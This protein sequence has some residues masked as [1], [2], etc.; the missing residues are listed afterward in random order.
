MEPE[1]V[2]EEDGIEWEEAEW[3]DESEIDW[4]KIN[5]E[6]NEMNVT[7]ASS[8][9]VVQGGEKKTKSKRPRLSMA[10]KI[11][12]HQL[13]L[14]CLLGR[15]MRIHQDIICFASTELNAQILSL[16]LVSSRLSRVEEEAA[17]TQAKLHSLVQWF[18]TVFEILPI[19]DHT[20]FELNQT[21]LRHVLVT[22]KG[23][24]FQVIVIFVV[25]CRM[26]GWNTRYTCAL[27]PRRYR[28]PSTYHRAYF[29]ENVELVALR[30]WDGEEEQKEPEKKR[31]RSDRVGCKT[32]VWSEIFCDELVS[33][34]ECDLSFS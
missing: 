11:R 12:Q 14:T 16:C 24:D 17:R 27:D 9:T 19:M 34:V 28:G 13:H 1:E 6:L 29:N 10:E 7:S 22:K 8:L 4:N 18:H 30:V 5:E 23:Y 33:I 3:N 15:E 21:D 32:R 31:P 2:D 26:L 20:E 25:L